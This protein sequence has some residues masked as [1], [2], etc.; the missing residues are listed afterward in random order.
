MSQKHLWNLM[1]GHVKNKLAAVQASKLTP[2][3]VDWWWWIVKQKRSYLD[4]MP[5]QVEK[6]GT[7]AFAFPRFPFPAPGWPQR[8]VAPTPS[9][10]LSPAFFY[11]APGP[12]CVLGF[13]PLLSSSP[14]LSFHSPSPSLPTNLVVGAVRRGGRVSR[15]AT[16]SKP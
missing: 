2:L 4:K 1:R 15:V 16:T 12:V 5:N 14:L 10:S 6:G 9:L 8:F 13:S 11:S 3:P 7:S